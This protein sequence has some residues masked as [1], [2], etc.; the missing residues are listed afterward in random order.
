[1]Y[2]CSIK[3]L[4]DKGKNKKVKFESSHIEFILTNNE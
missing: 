1:M 2:N 3:D 4:I